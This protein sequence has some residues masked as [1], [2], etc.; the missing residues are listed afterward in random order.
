MK[1]A[2]LGLE[3]EQ[4]NFDKELALLVYELLYYDADT[5]DEDGD[6]ENLSRCYCQWVAYNILSNIRVSVIR[7]KSCEH[8]QS[9]RRALIKFSQVFD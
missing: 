1:Y 8:S 3:H 6:D 4:Q 5:S 9:L 2:F 7:Y